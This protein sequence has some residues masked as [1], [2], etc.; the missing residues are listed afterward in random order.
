MQSRPL[1][2]KEWESEFLS[3]ASAL[4]P[5]EIAVVSPQ[6]PKNLSLFAIVLWVFWM[7]AP[8]TFK[9]SVLGARLP[10]RSLKIWGTCCWFHPFALREGGN[11]EFSPD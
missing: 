6:E 11:E 7:Q 10:D 9:A 8:L 3:R 5:G 4:S 1:S 2:G